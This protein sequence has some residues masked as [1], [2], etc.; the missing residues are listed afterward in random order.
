MDGM[1]GDLIK[2]NRKRLRLSQYELAR[3]IG[4]SRSAVYMWEKGDAAPEKKRI[5][6]LASVLGVD[7][8]L[9]LG[10][11]PAEQAGDGVLFSTTGRNTMPRSIAVYRTT[12]ASKAGEFTD[13]YLTEEVVNMIALPP[14]LAARSDIHAIFIHSDRM[15]PRYH[16]REMVYAGDIVP[17]EVNDYVVVVMKSADRTMKPC[18]VRRYLGR[19][20][21]RIRLQQL[22]PVR[23]KSIR[24]SEVERVLRIIPTAELA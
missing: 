8:M 17:P 6:K 3:E 18:A 13:F 15:E 14:R 1:V 11:G 20:G 23:T 12:E 10:E 9:F 24:L 2:V 22:N 4:V 5:P 7:A 19:D 16:P 21:D